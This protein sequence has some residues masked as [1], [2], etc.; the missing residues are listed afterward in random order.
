MG[1][2]GDTDDSWSRVVFFPGRQLFAYNI[3]PTT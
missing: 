1:E 3:L 2:N